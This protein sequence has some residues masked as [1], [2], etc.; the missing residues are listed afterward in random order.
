M[1]S[2]ASPVWS[3]TACAPV[4]RPF[5]HRRRIAECSAGFQERSSQKE[6]VDDVGMTEHY[7]IHILA[8]GTLLYFSSTDRTVAKQDLEAPNE[9]E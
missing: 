5:V 2:T 4:C 6:T 9:P 7:D 1:T 8:A 3:V